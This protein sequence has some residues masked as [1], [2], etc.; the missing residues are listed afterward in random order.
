[1]ASIS[2]TAANIIASLGIK[3]ATDGT[4]PLELA[5][6]FV[7]VLGADGKLSVNFIPS[8]AAQMSVPPLYNV[9][10]VD[11]NTTATERNGSIAAPFKSLS[12]ASGFGPNGGKV[13]LIL[14]PGDYSTGALSLTR[15]GELYIIG[16]GECW[17]TADPINIGMRS[18]SLLFLQNVSMSV[19]ARMNV[20]GASGIYCLGRT[21]LATLTGGSWLKLSSEA[22]VDSTDIENIT[23]LSEDSRIGNTSGV[24]GATVKDA[25]G[26]LGRRT[27]RVSKIVDESSC[28]VVDSSSSYD[29]ISA[30]SVGGGQ[31]VYDLTSRDRILM[32]AINR[33]IRPQTDLVVNSVTA[34]TVTAGQVDAGGVRANVFS[35]GGYHLTVDA[36]GYLVVDEGSDSPQPIPEGIVLIRDSQTG[37]L[38]TIGVENGRMYL[39]N[40]E[41]ES[42][43]SV[44]Y[45]INVVEDETGNEYTIRVENGRI[46]ISGPQE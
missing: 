2:P 5:S 46:I 19:G 41:D 18:G 38:Y 12:E 33:A 22:R 39:L 34:N 7:P 37:A 4:N 15:P 44:G 42:S 26:R 11:P 40:A 9:A 23:F 43:S 45:E 3:G 35:L 13:A 20:T 31:E 32:N 14:A 27:I 29:D 36:Y 8:G 21:Y 10:V 6:G 30:E 28:L 1:M 25:V 16:L 17:L 24:P